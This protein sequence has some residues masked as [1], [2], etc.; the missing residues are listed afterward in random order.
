MQ[1]LHMQQQNEYLKAIHSLYLGGVLH[2]QPHTIKEI[3]CTPTGTMQATLRGSL[4]PLVCE[5]VHEWMN[6]WQKP[7]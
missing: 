2:M 3:E 7:F 1:L 6:E 4:L 5:C